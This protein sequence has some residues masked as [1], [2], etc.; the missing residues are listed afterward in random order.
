M[1]HARNGIAI[2]SGKGHLILYSKTESECAKWFAAFETAT[3]HQLESYY[4]VKRIVGKGGFGYVRLG[5]D[6]AT[7]QY[8]AIKSI[9]KSGS[10]S[11]F[12]QREI[13]ILKEVQHP[14]VVELYDIFETDEKYHLVMEYM[15]GGMLCDV[16]TRRQKLNETDAL[17][18]LRQILRAVAYLHSRGIVHRDLKPENVLI[19]N[20]DELS[21]KL[22]DFGLSKFYEEASGLQFANRMPPVRCK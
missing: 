7:R 17:H 6:K 21:V 10:P 3:K 13:A 1:H 20:T 22:A 9:L 19:F 5:A 15:T 11:R 2:L 14:N 8:V 16:V 18:V 12:L 4:L